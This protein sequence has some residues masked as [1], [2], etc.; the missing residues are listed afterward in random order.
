MDEENI[1]SILSQYNINVVD[2]KKQ[3][4][5]GKKAIWWIKTTRW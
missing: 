3:S 1:N 4:D 5:K 2:I